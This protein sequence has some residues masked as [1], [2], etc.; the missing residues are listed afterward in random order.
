MMPLFYNSIGQYNIWCVVEQQNEIR[1]GSCGNNFLGQ[2]TH[3]VLQENEIGVKF[4]NGDC[5]SCDDVLLLD[6]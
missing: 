1:L 4:F 3:F 5:V 6:L 2:W